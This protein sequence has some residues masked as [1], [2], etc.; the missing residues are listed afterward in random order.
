VAQ[1]K[2]RRFTGEHKQRILTA[3]DQ[4][5]GSGGIGALLRREGLSLFRTSSPEL[6]RGGNQPEYCNDIY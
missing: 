3:A 4:A 5:K 2:R 6:R 1:A